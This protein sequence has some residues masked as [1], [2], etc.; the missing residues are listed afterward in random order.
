MTIDDL[1]AEI[2]QIRTSDLAGNLKASR[3][4]SLRCKLRKLG[5]EPTATGDSEIWC[6]PRHGCDNRLVA[7]VPMLDVWCNRHTGGRVRMTHQ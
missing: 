5:Y 2:E 3:I 6:C 4:F 1:L 7:Y